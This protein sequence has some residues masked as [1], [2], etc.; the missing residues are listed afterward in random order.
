M[1]QQREQ[2]L[3]I[4]DALG[5]APFARFYADEGMFGKHIMGD[6]G[7]ANKQE[8]LNKIIQLFNLPILEEN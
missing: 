7:A 1:N 5:K 8:V 2:A 3:A 6:R 4:Y